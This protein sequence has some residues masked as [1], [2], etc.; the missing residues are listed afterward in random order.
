LCGDDADPDRDGL[1]N[2]Q[3]YKAG[4]DPNNADSD[5]DGLSDGD[6]VNVF[7]TNPISPRTANDPK[8]NDADYIKGGYSVKSQKVY[9][10]AELTAV[11]QRMQ[12][13][14][15]T[16]P[17]LK[18]LGD[19]LITLY[20][21]SVPPNPNPAAAPVASSTP[22]ASASSTLDQSPEAKQSRDTQRS[23]TVSTISIA[24]LKYQSV[25]QT[26]P[27]T[28]SFPEMIAAIKPY[29]LVATNSV[30]P[31]NKDPYMY[32]YAS[33][34]GGKD[35]LLTFYS[36][37]QNTLIKMT[38][39]DAL[40]AKADAQ[41]QSNDDQRK[42]DLESIQSALLL[43]SSKNVAGNQDYVFPTTQKYKTSIVP[44]YLSSVPKDPVTGQEYQYQVSSTFDSFTL[45]ATLQAPPSGNTGYMCNQDDCQYY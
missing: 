30:D 25:E 42:M 13:F 9:T 17:T 39:A 11:M 38:S 5:Q 34:N 45:K 40:K 23:V 10:S 21:F 29:N 43:Y 35:F 2:I 26:Y 22:G 27:D 3:E 1:T 31:I 18:T 15:L 12:Q 6:E 37:T 36:E 20:H 8:Y 19:S 32:G 16:P 28:V 24:L 14:K 7:L 33:V 41:A 4:T 44:Q